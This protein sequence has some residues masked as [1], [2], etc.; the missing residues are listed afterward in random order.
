MKKDQ[1]HQEIK[2]IQLTRKSEVTELR[3]AI[4][5]AIFNNANEYLNPPIKNISYKGIEKDCH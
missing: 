1:C 4:K 3:K 5:T 2:V